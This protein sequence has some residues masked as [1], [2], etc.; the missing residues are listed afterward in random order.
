MQT[1]TVA[2]TKVHISALYSSLFPPVSLSVLDLHSL[3]AYM[4]RQNGLMVAIR[5]DSGT[6]HMLTDAISHLVEE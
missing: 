3:A 2:V 6:D 4:H 1:A 5:C